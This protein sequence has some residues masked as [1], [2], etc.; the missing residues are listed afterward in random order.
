MVYTIQTVHCIP[1]PKHNHYSADVEV[2]FSL[3]CAQKPK[4][5]F[6]IIIYYL[7]HFAIK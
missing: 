3:F 4:K 2:M 1:T 5:D 7:G 6:I